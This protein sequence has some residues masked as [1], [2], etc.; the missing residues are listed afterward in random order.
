MKLLKEY[1]A[2]GTDRIAPIPAMAAAEA[3]RD[4]TLNLR[5]IPTLLPDGDAAHARD[6]GD[7][8][9]AAA[10]YK[11]CMAEDAP[12]PQIYKPQILPSTTNSFFRCL[13]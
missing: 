8:V 4:E 11:L 6:E 12:P 7:A 10:A 1:E 5:A 2:L 9:V 3:G 13:L